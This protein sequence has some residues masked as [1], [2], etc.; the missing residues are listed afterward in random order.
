MTQE[1]GLGL[2]TSGT[3]LFVFVRLA[4]DGLVPP[5]A[6]AGVGDVHYQTARYDEGVSQGLSQR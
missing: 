3:E 2:V 6:S 5:H 4:W 1:R